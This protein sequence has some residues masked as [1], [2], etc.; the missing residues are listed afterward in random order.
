MIPSGAP[1]NEML[2]GDDTGEDAI[3]TKGA[4]LV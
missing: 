4:V 1:H 2:M 3:G